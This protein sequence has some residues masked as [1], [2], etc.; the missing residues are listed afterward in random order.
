MTELLPCPFCGKA[1]TVRQDEPDQGWNGDTWCFIRCSNCGASPYVGESAS[2]RYWCQVKHS[3]VECN[4]PKQA[5]QKAY[6]A[7]ITAWNTR[8]PQ[9]R[10]PLTDEQI[11]SAYW[12]TPPF[13]SPHEAFKAGVKFAEA[14]GKL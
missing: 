12:K 13:Y 11:D 2:L 4:T 7:A 8:A 6:E 10:E 9:H 1:P 5:K 14:E 3:Y